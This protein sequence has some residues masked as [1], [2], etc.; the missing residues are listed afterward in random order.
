MPKPSKLS[1]WVFFVCLFLLDWSKECEKG[2]Y[3]SVV[4]DEIVPFYGK[5]YYSEKVYVLNY[6]RELIP[7]LETPQELNE[8]GYKARDLYPA[9]RPDGCASFDIMCNRL[10]D[11][12]YSEEYD[13]I[14]KIKS[15]DVKEGEWIIG[16]GYSHE[17]FAERRHLAP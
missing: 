8:K 5:G 12:S 2:Q 4:D 1:C 17:G 14:Q 16:S 13:L 6:V 9:F 3:I 7:V 11:Y 10:K 15:A